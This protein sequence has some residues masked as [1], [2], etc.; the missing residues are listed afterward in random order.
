LEEESA[1]EA[2]LAVPE[3]SCPRNASSITVTFSGW[4]SG[5][6]PRPRSKMCGPFEKAMQGMPGWR[7]F[8]SAMI[9]LTGAIAYLLNAPPFSGPA[10]LSLGQGD[11]AQSRTKPPRSNEKPADDVAVRSDRVWQSPILAERRDSK[12]RL[13]RFGLSTCPENAMIAHAAS[14]VRAARDDRRV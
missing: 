2:A 1:V 7:D 11:H 6:V 9:R 4:A 14:L 12:R 13:A 8:S 3:L 10:Q 5:M